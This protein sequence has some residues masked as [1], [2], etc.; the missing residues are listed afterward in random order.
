M[1]AYKRNMKRF[2]NTKRS[3][4]ETRDVEPNSETILFPITAT[5]QEMYT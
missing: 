4:E 1:S 5:D 2:T 3:V